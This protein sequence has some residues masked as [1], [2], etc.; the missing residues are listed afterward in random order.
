MS[1]A[2][3]L[4]PTGAVI[5]ILLISIGLFVRVQVQFDISDK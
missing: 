1:K 3:A 2:L 5:G 4:P